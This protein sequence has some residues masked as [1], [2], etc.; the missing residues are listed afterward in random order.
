MK[1]HVLISLLLFACTAVWGKGVPQEAAA[2]FAAIYDK[3]D[4]RPRVFNGRWLK[5]STYV[6]WEPGQNGS[7]RELALYHPA[8]GERTVL[9]T[10]FQL[11][12]T[13]RKTSE[14]RQSVCT[15]RP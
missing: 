9:V 5:D 8:T 13:E 11:I 14:S 12:P 6:V 7:G 3:D 1:L 10:S 2:R 15:A 4:Y